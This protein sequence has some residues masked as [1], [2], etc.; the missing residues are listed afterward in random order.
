MALS[1]RGGGK[2]FTLQIDQVAGIDLSK[3]E[4]EQA[5]RRQSVA[6]KLN[7]KDGA[8]DVLLQMMDT[9]EKAE[10]N[11]NTETQLRVQLE[12]T[13]E[14][15]L[16]DLNKRLLIEVKAR[17]Q[18][19]KTLEE[20]VKIEGSL[21]SEIELLRAKLRFLVDRQTFAVEDQAEHL[22]LMGLTDDIEGRLSEMSGLLD[23]DL[24]GIDQ[25]PAIQAL[26]DKVN[27]ES[28]SRLQLEARS[29]NLEYTIEDLLGKLEEERAISSNLRKK[30]EALEQRR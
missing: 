16:S 6:A 9:L 20:A 14:G 21:L 29:S 1:P 18:F 8:S 10:K 23:M 27:H 11:M 15:E 24:A 17:E 12:T 7:K 26:S 2:R 3:I 5:K 30:V 19:K 22:D 13:I 28:H 4:A 25:S